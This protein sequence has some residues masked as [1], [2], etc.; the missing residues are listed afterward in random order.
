MS[1]RDMIVDVF[2][3]TDVLDAMLMPNLKIGQVA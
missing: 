3:F 2:C 1:E